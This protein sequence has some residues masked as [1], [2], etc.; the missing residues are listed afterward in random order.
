MALNDI[1]KLVEQL[2]EISASFV[3]ADPADLQEF[4]NSHTFFEELTS[5]QSLN[6]KKMSAECAVLLEKLILGE[7]E[8]TYAIN[9]LSE[10]ISGLKRHLENQLYNGSGD[11]TETGC[12]VYDQPKKASA[13]A[14]SNTD[15]EIFRNFLSTQENTL[16]E[17]ERCILDLE[18]GGDISEFRRILHTLKGEAGVLGL[19]EIEHICHKTEDYIERLNK[20][21][22][23]D[24][25]LLV[26][27][28]LQ[29]TF[30]SFSGKQG[31]N[32]TVEEVVEILDDSE[33]G[34]Q[35]LGHVQFDS[36]IDL[37]HTDHSLLAD[38]ITES[39]E[40]LHNADNLLLELES[41]TGDVELINSLFRVFHT[42]KGIA[43]FLSLH[44]IQSL[45]HAT[46][47][48]LDKART[49]EIEL[50]GRL[51]DSVFISV[52]VLKGEMLLLRDALE[53]GVAYKANRKNVAAI[54]DQIQSSIRIKEDK[55]RIGEILIED[56]K[57][58]ENQVQQALRKQLEDPGKRIGEILVESKFVSE[59]DIRQACSKQQRGKKA[60]SVKNTIKVETEKLDRLIEAIGELVVTE[61][62][63]TGD[64]NVLRNVSSHTL[65]NIRQLDKITR[66]LQEIGLSMR[67]VS[68]KSTFQKMAR[69]VRDLSKKSGK[70]IEFVSSGEDTE[71]DKSVIERIGDPLVHM[72]RNSADHG[73]EMPQERLRTGKS[74]SGTIH[75]RAFQTSG[76]ICIEIEDDGR[77]L[78]KEAIL[79]KALKKGLV[80][81]GD[82]L[83]DQEIFGLVFHPGFS[84]AKE[85]T[86]ISGRGVGMDVVKKNVRDLRGNIEVRSERGKGSVFS[87]Y[88]PLTMAIMDGM[89]VK[90]GK[91]RYIIPT[92]SV[93]ESFR[94]VSDDIT[95]VLDKGEMVRCHDQLIPVIHLSALFT[96]GHM[97]HPSEAIVM[98]VE[99]MGKRVGLVVDMII[100]Q[101]QTVIKNLG[102]GMG[103]IEGV[104]GGAIMP[105]GNVSLIIDI[106]AMVK[107]AGN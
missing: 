60:L 53:K 23:S 87:I 107:M 4:A 8:F 90:A 81:Q 64:Q 22:N 47:E 9:Q 45:A 79:E 97:K 21:V 72:V 92:L 103:K 86:D 106:G 104:S 3:L 62:M 59:N 1:S 39:D 31:K 83:T 50:S 91:E 49:G 16:E 88:L 73:I 57:V 27:D 51:I 36:E 33:G 10:K 65:K 35:P 89:V 55:K 98:V 84:T 95:V 69:L 28:C 85:V 34:A 14:L 38:F 2:E 52:D 74:Q 48:L 25:L 40:H 41:N 20:D 78:D 70:Q 66:Q 29:N 26:K 102:E 46:E 56:G 7:V 24:K 68:M 93:V 61:A 75:L 63:V 13:P 6:C 100:G 101:Q 37:A 76:M 42:V 105:D 67:M 94:P 96:A 32:V 5:Y 15:K 71:L 11:L 18:K 19:Q 54:I 99:E 17:M 30:D 80:K 44:A 82:S 43:G 58:S 12:N 77:G